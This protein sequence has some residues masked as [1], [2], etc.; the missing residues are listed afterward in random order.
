MPAV[1]AARAVNGEWDGE[2]ERGRGRERNTRAR[3]SPSPHRPPSAFLLILMPRAR[4]LYIVSSPPAVGRQDATPRLGGVGEC[5]IEN[6]ERK[7]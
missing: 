3:L 7:S 4:M 6:A 5:G 2:K 1:E